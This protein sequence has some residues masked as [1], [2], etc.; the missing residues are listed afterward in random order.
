MDHI[1]YLVLG[2]HG[3]LRMQ[4]KEE[5]VITTK[6]VIVNKYKNQLNKIHAIFE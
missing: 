6:H 5:E 4:R 3:D 1:S 2:L